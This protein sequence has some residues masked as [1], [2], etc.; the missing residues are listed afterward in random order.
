MKEAKAR[1]GRFI[2]LIRPLLAS[3]REATM[4][5][6]EFLRQEGNEVEAVSF[7]RERGARLDL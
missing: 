1:R 4:A 6:R 7:L 5:L 2:R 3:Q